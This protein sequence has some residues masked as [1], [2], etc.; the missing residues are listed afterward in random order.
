M[1]TPPL[2]KVKRVSNEAT[3]EERRKLILAMIDGYI[4]DNKKFQLKYE[5]DRVN[6]YADFDEQIVSLDKITISYD[7]NEW[8]M[9]NA[10]HCFG[11]DSEV[12]ITFKTLHLLLDDKLID[13]SEDDCLMPN[14][15]EYRSRL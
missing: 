2:R 12:V 3:P 8:I 7:G 14:K 1:D 5:V 4:I 6:T 10:F 11:F 15:N 13:I 9:F